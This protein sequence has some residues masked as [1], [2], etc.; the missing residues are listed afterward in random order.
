[1]EELIIRKAICGICQHQ[2]ILKD[3]EKMPEK[4]PACSNGN[5][6][7][8]EDKSMERNIFGYKHVDKW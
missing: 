8:Y 3:D 5:P 6:I 4:C 7:S 2:I 1:M